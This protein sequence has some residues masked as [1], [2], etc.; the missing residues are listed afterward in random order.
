MASTHGLVESA[1]QTAVEGL[2]RYYQ[3]Y[4]R[5]FHYTVRADRQGHPKP[6]GYSVRYG[7]ISQIGI[8]RWLK[9][10]PEDG[11]RLPDLQQRISG[12]IDAIN[13]VGDAALWV[14]AFCESRR[15][16][17]GPLVHRLVPLWKGRSAG[18][19]AME[20]AWVLKACAMVYE[21]CPDHRGAIETTMREAETR[22]G[23]LFSPASKLFRRHARDGY[24]RR[25]RGTH[26]LLCRP[27]L[28]RGGVHALWGSLRRGTSPPHGGR[29][30]RD[31]LP[32]AGTAGTVVVAL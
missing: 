17:P 10:H 7:A 19:N 11:A 13:D 30:G 2:G 21:G 12:R 9:H 14:W 28:S 24:L 26:R 29:H 31:R 1:A 6:R 20:L 5:E 18:C 27:S 16:D 8:S 4:P 23:R 32:P 22:L 25:S 15:E 3:H